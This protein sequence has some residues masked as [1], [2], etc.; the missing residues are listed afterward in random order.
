MQVSK[1]SETQVQLNLR[2]GS[3]K[4]VDAAAEAGIA[5]VRFYQTEKWLVG[6]RGEN[7]YVVTKNTLPEPLAKAF[8]RS[9]GSDP[10]TENLVY[11]RKRFTI[12]EYP[13]FDDPTGKNARVTIWSH[14]L[15]NNIA[16]IELDKDTFVVKLFNQPK[17]GVFPFDKDQFL[18]VIDVA[19]WQLELYCLPKN[20]SEPDSE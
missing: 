9:A 5:K 6:K 10:V 2:S 15:E 20:Y 7:T 8:V 14:L 19:K 16:D 1:R 12:D 3:P 11:D 13:D 4:P 18:K 17:T